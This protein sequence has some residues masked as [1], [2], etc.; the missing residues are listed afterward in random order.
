MLFGSG[1][2]GAGLRI[3]RC[4]RGSGGAATHRRYALRVALT[5]AAAL[6]VAA[7]GHSPAKSAS[8]AGPAWVVDSVPVTDIAGTMPSGDVAFLSVVGAVRL[9]NGEIVIADPYDSKVRFF[10]AAGQQI[11]VYGRAGK[12]PGE[13]GRV[14]WIGRCGGD[15]VYTWDDQFHLTVVDS[16]G[17]LVRQVP[18][19]A[20]STGGTLPAL[21]ACNSESTLAFLDPDYSTMP[22]SVRSEAF[23]KG[24]V[25]VM[26]QHG[27]GAR[28][29]DTVPAAQMRPFARFAQLAVSTDRFFLGPED[30]ARVLWYALEGQTRGSVPL[31]GVGRPVTNREYEA[32]IQQQVAVI[33]N[34]QQRETAMKQMLR[35]PKPETLAPYFALFAVGHD[36]LWAQISAPGDSVTVLDA[37]GPD[38]KPAG[39]ARIPRELRVLDMG[40]DYIL[41]E[42]DAPDG[43]EHVALYRMHPPATR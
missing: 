9:S 7:C 34:A 36:T 40:R 32:A 15:T 1:A 38:G 14:R 4:L 33:P 18:L 8:S 24:A 27:R 30:S 39:E 42:Y 17:V 12:G 2:V 13:L 5:L 28:I 35:I 11:H 16:S 26:D 29:L 21:L 22:A 31:G 20:E 19:P 41:G 43:D 6:G 25:G 37:V 3:R 10:D 23:G